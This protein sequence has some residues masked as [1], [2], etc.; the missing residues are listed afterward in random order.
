MLIDTRIIHQHDRTDVLAQRHE[1]MF[2]DGSSL[3]LHL[4]RQHDIEAPLLRAVQIDGTWCLLDFQR[5]LPG[6]AEDILS[7]HRRDAQ[8]LVWFTLRGR[9]GSAGGCIDSLRPHLQPL[10]GGGGAAIPLPLGDPLRITAAP[11]GQRA[12]AGDR[13][14]LAAA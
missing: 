12:G 14:E 10:Q 8:G 2:R 4:V 1:V 9:W 6:L 13:F 3:H 5:A 11:L 7:Q